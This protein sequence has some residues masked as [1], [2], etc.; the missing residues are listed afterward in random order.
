M[1]AWG[2]GPF[3]NDGALDL[4][5]GLDGAA[6][7]A[8]ALAGAMREIL[9]ETD[10]VES[11]EMSGAVAAACLVG[12]RVI[13]AESD[14][15]ATRWLEANPFEADAGLRALA[16]SL[17]ERAVRPDDNEVYELWDDAGGLR[18]WLDTLTPYREALI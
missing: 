3:D 13:G 5:G 15:V 6:D 9:A 4:L 18:G 14:R 16:V 11:P 10:Y 7:P 2:S 12:A 17:L 8:G 1:G